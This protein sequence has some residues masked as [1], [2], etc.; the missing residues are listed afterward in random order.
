MKKWLFLPIEIEVRELDA[1]IL[2]A[3]EAVNRGFNVVI[4]NPRIL[5]V[6][7]FFPKGIYFSKDSDGLNYE[8]F[9]NYRKLGGKVCV[10]DEEGLVH[11]NDKSYISL[12]LDFPTLKE[13]DLYLCWGDHQKSIIDN[14]KSK[15]TSSLKTIS[16]GHP[17]IDLLKKEKVLN[18]KKTN[19]ILINTKLTGF[20]IKGKNKGNSLLKVLKAHNMIKDKENEDFFKG[21]EIYQEKLFYK[22]VE[23][24]KY[25][26][27]QFKDKQI[28]LRPH[29]GEDLENWKNLVKNLS[30]VIVT[31][32]NSI[33][34]WIKKSD[35]IIHTGCTTG[36]EAV[37][38]NRLTIS[39]QPVDDNKYKIPLPD[40][41][42]HFE[43]KIKEE[44]KNIIENFY[45]DNLKI[46]DKTEILNHY[47]KIDE[48]KFAYEYIVDELEKIAFD[49]TNLNFINKK[50]IKFLL[51]RKKWN[52]DKMRLYN[53]TDFL[54][55]VK[56]L[57]VKFNLDISNL[58]I[59]ELA[60]NLFLLSKK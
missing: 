50:I 39:Y 51:N 28:I 47:L 20:N 8:N 59:E 29:P 15:Y 13:I 9:K 31:N 44:V 43:I 26:S 6:L 3:L 18:Y 41:V 36:L 53:K 37:L 48:N 27:A 24:I 14:F 54:K 7:K 52:S 56:D 32:E 30:N 2:I 25:L 11:F 1:K 17:R 34:Y 23:L 35:L 33:S 60:Q 46:K 42:S 58:E 21:Y 57:A 45:N 38:M 12:R 22:Y 49:S 10:H 4:G 16:T 19:L 55:K 40:E 5:K